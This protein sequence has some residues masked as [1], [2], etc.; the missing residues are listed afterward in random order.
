MKTAYRG[1]DLA[2]L[3][4]NVGDTLPLQPL[5]SEFHGIVTPLLADPQRFVSNRLAKHSCHPRLPRHLQ[6][7][8]CSRD[9]PPLEAPVEF[10]LPAPSCLPRLRAS[11]RPRMQLWACS[12]RG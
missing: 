4:G 1:D 2:K 6:R 7:R 12:D 8:V 3:C 5:L 10:H 9:P 11:L